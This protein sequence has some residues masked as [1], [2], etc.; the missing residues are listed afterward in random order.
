M[1]ALRSAD[2]N[3]DPGGFEC[4]ICFEL[5]Q[6]PIVTLCGH[7]YCWPCLYEWLQVHSHS[8]ECPVCK[9]LVEEHKLVP[10]YGRGKSSSDPRSRLVPG[11]NIPKRPMGQRP[12]TAPAV[13]MDYLR[14]DELDPIGGFRPVPMP[15]PMPSARFG[16]SMLS[17]L[18]GAIPAFFNLHVHGFHD[19]TVYGATTGVPYLFSG[20]F[21][22]GYAHGFH[23]SNHLDGTKFFMKMLF[24]IIGFL[25]IISL[26][27]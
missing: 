12:Q 1:D 4:N 2:M 23:Y 16:N 9:A 14:H 5:A 22:G 8:Y 3:S 7:L 11:I 27:S 15:M 20:S 18:F 24:L 25:L 17:D 19:A 26:I 13:D 10:I 6:D 21:H